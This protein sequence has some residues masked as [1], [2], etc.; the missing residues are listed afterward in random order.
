MSKLALEKLREHLGEEL[1]ESHDFRGDETVV[2]ARER[3]VETC[4][5]LKEH[6]DLRFTMLADLTAVDLLPSEPRFEVVYHLH[7]IPS[8]ARVR[9]KVRLPEEDPVVPTLCGLYA[10]ANWLEREVYDLYGIRFDG[11][12]DLRRILLYESFEGHPL[13]KDY[14][15]DRHPPLSRRPEAEI[16]AVLA[17]S[18]RARPLPEPTEAAGPTAHKERRGAP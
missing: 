2:V 10:I 18:G 5:F 4:R 11:H 13:R 15:K 3:I 12:P 9:L 17:R 7:S 8:R 1:L 6:P 16:E 14:E